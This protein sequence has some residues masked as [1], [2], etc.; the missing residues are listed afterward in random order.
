V[1]IECFI[2]NIS[3]STHG[4]IAG[5]VIGDDDEDC[6]VSSA[7]AHEEDEDLQ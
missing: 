1:L 5:N 4:D 6:L 3:D 2:L 7:K